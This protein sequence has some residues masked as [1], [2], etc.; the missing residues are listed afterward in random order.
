MGSWGI[1]MRQSDQGLDWLDF[2]ILPSLPLRR[3]L[4]KA[5]SFSPEDRFQDA[6]AFSDALAGFPLKREQTESRHKRLLIVLLCAL[7]ASLAAGVGFRESRTVKFSSQ[8]ME[9]A[10]RLELNKPEGRVTYNDLSRIRHLGV[11]G[12]YVF[13]AEQVFT[14]VESN[15]RIGDVFYAHEGNTGFLFS[16]VCAEF[17]EF[18]QFEFLFF[19]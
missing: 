1:T 13:P 14:Y 9:A 4:E 5:V 2:T 7:L 12:D 18:L 15:Y 6:A 10:V 17:S 19:N 16:D 8:F 3:A 11:V